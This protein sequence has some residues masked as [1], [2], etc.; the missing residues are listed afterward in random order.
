ME[1]KLNQ[2]NGSYENNL[3]NQANKAAMK[4]QMGESQLYQLS[5]QVEAFKQMV[6]YKELPEDDIA[7]EDSLSILHPHIWKAR[8]EKILYET[9]KVYQDKVL[10]NHLLNS[11][12]LL[13]YID[14]KLMSADGATFKVDMSSMGNVVG[15]TPSIA[16]HPFELEQVEN[17][18]K[19]D[20][21]NFLAEELEALIKKGDFENEKERRTAEYNLKSLKLYGLQ[22]EVRQQ[23][24]Q[25]YMTCRVALDHYGMQTLGDIM[26]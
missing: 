21:A 23:V 9:Q 24:L 1:Q 16:G 6:L 4:A 8:R 3:Q 12:N 13:G 17:L 18:L 25:N 19:V 2:N 11:H 15:G 22:Q 20:Q 10:N 14:R 5:A 7:L 26:Y